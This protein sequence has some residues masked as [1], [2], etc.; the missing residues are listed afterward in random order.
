MTHLVRFKVIL[1]NPSK[2][3]LTLDRVEILH[4]CSSHLHT[5]NES[6]E[7]CPYGET[8][9][10]VRACIAVEEHNILKIKGLRIHLLGTSCDHLTDRR[11]LSFFKLPFSVL[12]GDQGTIE[13]PLNSKPF[14]WDM[15]N[16][17]LEKPR[18]HP[19]SL[20][21][22]SDNFILEGD[23]SRA[24]DLM[25]GELYDLTITFDCADPS[26]WVELKFK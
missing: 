25:E 1:F 8:E 17:I 11:G 18:E 21:L 7:L 15:D 19:V 23:G 22:S 20:A 3:D 9:I 4:E 6:F 24:L 26:E 16:I 13:R 12:R 2:T 10:I 14:Q 5:I